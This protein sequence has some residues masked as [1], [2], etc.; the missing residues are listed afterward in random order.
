MV[1]Q[2]AFTLSSDERTSADMFEYGEVETIS[3]DQF[4][5]EHLCGGW[6][7]ALLKTNAA[8]I[9]ALIINEEDKDK[10]ELEEVQARDPRAGIQNGELASKLNWHS[11]KSSTLWLRRGRAQGSCDS[12]TVEQ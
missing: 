9:Y 7:L 6:R 11:L 4:E 12:C 10:D 2:I 5:F 1:R 3:M 8:F